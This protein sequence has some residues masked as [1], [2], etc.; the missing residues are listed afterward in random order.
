MDKYIEEIHRIRREHE[1]EMKEKSR[2]EWKESVRAEA[3]TFLGRKITLHAGEQPP[4][5]TESPVLPVS[6]ATEMPNNY[7]HSR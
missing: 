6:V 3:E 5:R 7:I 4:K 1:E 2:E